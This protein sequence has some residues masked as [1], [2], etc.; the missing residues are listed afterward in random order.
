MKKEYRSP[1]KCP[2]FQTKRKSDERGKFY[3]S[4]FF[5][6]IEFFTIE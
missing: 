1:V 4:A 5:H 3:A 2:L 6:F